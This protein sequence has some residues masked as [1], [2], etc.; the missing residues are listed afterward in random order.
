MTTD[1]E[2]LRIIDAAV[3]KAVQIAG[4][5]IKCKPGCSHCC[6]GPFAVTERDLERLRAG[7]ASLPAAQ[8]HRLADRSREAR[9]AMRAGF[10]G[11]WESGTLLSQEAADAFDL[12][13]P[14]L[15]CPILDLESGAC[16]LHPWRPV[17]CR[18]HGP[19]LRING[20]NLRPCRLNYSGVDPEGLRVAIETPEGAPS[21]LTYIAWAAKA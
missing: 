19:A 20:V 11:D 5:S 16:S 12:Q 4:E 3:T 21:P 18:L 7:F 15:P 9:A 1:G 14:W 8:N 17:A 13:H 2:L 10:P 6:I